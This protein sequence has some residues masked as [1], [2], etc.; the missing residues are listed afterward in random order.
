[1]CL[2]IAKFFTVIDLCSACF[3]VPLAEESQYLFIDYVDMI[4]TVQGKRYM[5]VVIDRF[6]RW[7]EATWELRQW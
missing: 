3:S 2:L 5:L 1:M 6:S 4:K 7:V